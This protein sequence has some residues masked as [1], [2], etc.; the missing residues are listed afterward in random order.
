[1]RDVEV[2]LVVD[3][4]CVRD[5]HG[6]TPKAIHVVTI[7]AIA[8]V[9]KS[10]R[11]GGAMV[12]TVCLACTHKKKDGDTCISRKAPWKHFGSTLALWIS[13]GA[14]GGESRHETKARG[15]SRLSHSADMRAASHRMSAHDAC[16]TCGAGGS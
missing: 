1:M 5:S 12:R 8:R 15:A 6:C 11:E 10:E 2:V 16:G 4:R 14:L 9:A 13:W 3:V 7:T